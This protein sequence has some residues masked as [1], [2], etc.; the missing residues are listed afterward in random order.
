MAS[1]SLAFTGLAGIKPSY[2]R[3]PAYPASPFGMLSHI[4]PMAR[5]V[6]DAALMLSVM[7]GA[8]WRDIRAL[9]PDGRDWRDDIE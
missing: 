4:G 3:V 2:G 8:D 5:T 6:T 7:A 9:P 1:A